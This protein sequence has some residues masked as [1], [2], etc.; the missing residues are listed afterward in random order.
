MPHDAGFLGF[1]PL[2]W[3]IGDVGF[4]LRGIE[5]ILSGIEKRDADVAHGGVL[6]DILVLPEF[7]AGDVV[8]VVPGATG[9]VT[10]VGT[11]TQGPLPHAPD[12]RDGRVGRIGGKADGEGHRFGL[13]PCEPAV[14]RITALHKA[15][16]VFF[17]RG[18][19]VPQAVEAAAPGQH[20]LL[21]GR[22]RT[23]MGQGRG[24]GQDYRLGPG[25]SAVRAP[26]EH[27]VLVIRRF[28]RSLGPE[29]IQE[30]ASRVFQHMEMVVERIAH[31]VAVPFGF[32]GRLFGN[33]DGI[34]VRNHIRVDAG[35]QVVPVKMVGPAFAE[36][37]YVRKMFRQRF[38]GR[39]IPVAG[40][41]RFCKNRPLG[42]GGGVLSGQAHPDCRAAFGRPGG[43]QG[44]HGG[45]H[46]VPVPNGRFGK[47]LGKVPPVEFP[48]RLA[49]E[50]RFRPQDG[51]PEKGLLCQPVPLQVVGF[52]ECG[53][54]GIRQAE[55][56]GPVPPRPVPAPFARIADDVLAAQ[57]VEGVFPI[58]SSGTRC[59]TQWRPRTTA[60][61]H[62]S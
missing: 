37:S 41:G 23:R 5:R 4:H 6:V 3:R 51:V 2:P 43:M 56:E 12:G 24:S 27:H 60:Q 38:V 59:A 22:H 11:E 19:L 20:G 15:A 53:G 49:G 28:E 61:I 25:L 36:V 14:V 32:H 10:S 48:G 62:P 18:L 57:E 54:V 52:G 29:S 17:D 33:I 31:G 39:R 58:S 13:G 30:A 34:I 45:Q 42:L 1:L 47:Q 40:F 8:A 9:Q 21:P 7:H 46:S 35:V 26:R 50:G 55:I 16:E 44:K